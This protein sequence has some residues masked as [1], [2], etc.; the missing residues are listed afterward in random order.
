VRFEVGASSGVDCATL[1]Q[2]L[3]L[4]VFLIVSVSFLSPILLCRHDTCSALNTSAVIVK[5]FSEEYM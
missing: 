5:L 1:G 2:C 3:R 4:R